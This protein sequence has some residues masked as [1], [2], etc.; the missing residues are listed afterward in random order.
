[1]NSFNFL[2]GNYEKNN[3]TVKM[4][5]FCKIRAEF[6]LNVFFCRC[7][8]FLCVYVLVLLAVSLC[9]LHNVQQSDVKDETKFITRAYTEQTTLKPLSV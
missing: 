6:V 3:K 9:A 7:E 8:L 4:N 1:M 5:V 2:A